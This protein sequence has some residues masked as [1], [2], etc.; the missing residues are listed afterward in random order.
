MVF[1][2]HARLFPFLAKELTTF[3]HYAEPEY[4]PVFASKINSSEHSQHPFPSAVI[5]YE[6]HKHR[7][8][9]TE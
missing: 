3:Y 5:V 2:E 1:A 8:T 9:H 7:Q 4:A 6:A